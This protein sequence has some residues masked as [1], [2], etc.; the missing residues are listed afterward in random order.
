MTYEITHD[1][2]RRYAQRADAVQIKAGLN[3]IAQLQERGTASDFAIT[4]LLQSQGLYKLT[5]LMLSVL[6]QGPDNTPQQAV[7]CAMQEANRTLRRQ[8][9]STSPVDRAQDAH[10]REAASRFLD[11]AEAFDA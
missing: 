1:E 9:Q 11:W 10:D 2:I 4:A 7:A 5:S 6:D 8:S 3:M